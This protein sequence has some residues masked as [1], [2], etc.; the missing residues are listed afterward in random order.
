MGGRTW[1]LGLEAASLRV[2]A[3]V[4]GGGGE[5]GRATERA[6]QAGTLSL[7]R[8]IALLGSNTAQPSA[9]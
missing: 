4:F 9:R 7:P 3:V 5:E 2:G 6:R 8:P 1:T